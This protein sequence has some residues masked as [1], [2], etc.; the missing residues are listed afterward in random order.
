MKYSASNNERKYILP[1]S[2]ILRGR[3]SIQRLF[4]DGR[5]VRDQNT[6]LR[7]LFFPEEPGNC[8]MGFIAGKRLGK[9]HERNVIKRRMREAYRLHQY[10]IQDAAATGNISIHG[11]FIAKKAGTPFAVIEMECKKLL[12]AVC[13]QIKSGD[14]S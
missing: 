8:L 10:I 2:R 11:I 5:V 14:R 7:Y 9:A 1:R 6:D 13:A 3:E 12:K 4:R